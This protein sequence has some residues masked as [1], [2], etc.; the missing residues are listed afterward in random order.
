M[1]LNH[2]ER[3]PSCLARVLSEQ[4][5]KLLSSIEELRR[6]GIAGRGSARPRGTVSTAAVSRLPAELERELFDIAAEA[7][8]QV[9]R[10]LV[11]ALSFWSGQRLAQFI[12]RLVIH[13][14][15]LESVDYYATALR[16]IGGPTATALLGKLCNDERSEVRAWA[17]AALA[18]LQTGGT[19][20]LAEGLVQ[21]E[22]EG[23]VP[24]EHSEALEP[25]ILF[26]GV[27]VA[28]PQPLAE[29]TTL[30]TQIAMAT[31]DHCF[32]ETTT[33][34]F[35]ILDVLPLESATRE[36]TRACEAVIDAGE[37]SSPLRD[38]P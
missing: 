35:G 10:E 13:E 34:A 30:R 33:L 16:T 6:L 36:R 12:D 38:A 29:I 5:T 27:E 26:E 11:L 8:V 23:L 31:L 1:G 19:L 3:L 21:D 15:D 2:T 25:H 7:Q 22:H 17:T 37:H 18:E 24:V 28:R 20:D 4:G 32:D 9:R 14:A